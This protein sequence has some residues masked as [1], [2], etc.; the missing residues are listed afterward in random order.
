MAKRLTNVPQRIVTNV[1]AILSKNRKDG[2]SAGPY[3]S[4]RPA[5]ST[6][7]I[8]WRHQFQLLRRTCRPLKRKKCCLLR[9]DFR[10]HTV[11]LKCPRRLNPM[12]WISIQLRWHR[13][14]LMSNWSSDHRSCTCTEQFLECF[15][16]WRYKNKFENFKRKIIKI[17]L[18]VNI[19]GEDQ[20][21]AD[22]DSSAALLDISGKN[23]S[24]NRSSDPIPDPLVTI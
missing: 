13:I 20:R 4:F 5:F 15:F 18:K 16:T 2:F 24:L 3:L 1:G 11:H 22:M 14:K 19:F 7:T 6:L 9:S 23:E 10:P 21:M 8:Q 17:C 12:Q